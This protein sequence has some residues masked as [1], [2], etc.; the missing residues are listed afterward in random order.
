MVLTHWNVSR[1]N[2][3]VLEASI[4]LLPQSLNCHTSD[5]ENIN[6]YKSEF[7]S[8]MNSFILNFKIDTHGRYNLYNLKFFFIT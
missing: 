8:L 4:G 3:N 7:S 6:I 5:S 1:V 2:I